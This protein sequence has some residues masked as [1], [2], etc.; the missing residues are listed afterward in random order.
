[1]VI[2][3]PTQIQIGSET[4]LSVEVEFFGKKKRGQPHQLW[5]RFPIQFQ[6]RISTDIDPFAVALLLVAMKNQEPLELRGSLSR[7]LF[8]GLKEYQRIYHSWYPQIFHEIEIRPTTLRD[9]SQ[10]QSTQVAC[11]FSGGV[12]SFYTL[13][14][15]M[16]QDD[17]MSKGKSNSTGLNYTLFMAGFDM[18]LQLTQ[19]ISELTRSYSVLMKELGIQFVI[20]STNI[21]S[22]VNTVDW[23][24]AHGQALGAAALF[25]KNSWNQFYIPSSYTSASY[26]KWGTHPSLDHLLSTETLRFV[27]HG[28]E[29]NRVSKLNLVSKYQDSYS[30]LRVCWIQNIGL[31]NCGE[32]EKCVRTLVALDI[33]NKRFLYTTFASDSLSSVKIR[34]LKMRTHQARLFAREL[35]WEAAKR[36]K[37]RV[38]LD[39]GFALLQRELFHRRV[40]GNKRRH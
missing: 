31:K 23:T 39:L 19:S 10:N 5:F 12:D 22:F 34:S 8:E 18:P 13:F 37:W 27:H 33:L 20:G 40:G 17:L 7:K 1:M 30:R 36:L 35:M 2:H 16:K 3:S 11:A 6:S 24:N 21:R 26:P 14:K 9:D 15:L 29:S 32:C 28:D 4:Q 38:L 25:F